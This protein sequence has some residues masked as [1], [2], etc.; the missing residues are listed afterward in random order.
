LEGGPGALKNA[1]LLRDRIALVRRGAIS[2]AE[3]A[4]VAQRVR[5]RR[6]HELSLSFFVFFLLCSHSCVQAGARAV[7]VAQVGSVWPY[8]MTDQSG[9]AGDVAVPVVMACA[10]DGE[11]LATLCARAEP[12]VLELVSLERRLACPVCREDFAVGT[13]AVRLP[14]THVYHKECIVEWL[15]KRSTCP[16]CRYQL[17]T[18]DR[19]RERDAQ[20]RA[21]QETIHA[22]MFT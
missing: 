15:A 5:R 8:T 16:L 12:C 7:V 21:N 13:P 2:F 20:T 10:Q 3:K 9:A 17:P 19:K 18:D 4:R 14:C 11:A 22:F 6:T 1:E